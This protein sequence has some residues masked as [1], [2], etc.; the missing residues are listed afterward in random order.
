[1]LFGQSTGALS[2]GRSQDAAKKLISA[3]DAALSGVLKR[4]QHGHFKFLLG[5]QKDWKDN[6]AYVHSFVKTHIDRAKQLQSGSKN[7][8]SESQKRFAFLDEL[9]LQN[10]DRDFL[11]NQ[12]LNIFFPARHSSAI[13]ISLVFFVVARNPRAFAKI[14]EDVLLCG[15][16]VTADNLKSMKHLQ[17]IL[18]ECE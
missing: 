8:A 2:P 18:Q 4:R 5:R 6:V 15:K 1:M 11:R 16:Q 3:F 12:L 14:R 9:I 7:C 13:G 10:D 17:Y